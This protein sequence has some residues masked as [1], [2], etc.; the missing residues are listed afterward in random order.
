MK[1]KKKKELTSSEMA[2]IRWSKTTP[3]Q[4]KAH[5]EKMNKAKKSKKSRK[6]GPK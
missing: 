3:E 1:N 6:T 5:S 2:K 4:R